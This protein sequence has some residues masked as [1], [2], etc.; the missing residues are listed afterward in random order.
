MSFN[1][2]ED[3]SGVFNDD[4]VN[5]AASYLNESETG[6]SKAL[7]GILP[8]VMKRLLEKSSGTHGINK[9]AQLAQEHYNN[10]I[11]ENPASFFEATGGSMLNKG[12]KLL[13]GLFDDDTDETAATISNFSGIRPASATTLMSIATPVVLGLLGKHAAKNNLNAAGL[14]SSLGVEKKNITAIIP[15]GLDMELINAAIITPDAVVI[16]EEE[17]NNGL[18]WLLPLLL[19]VLSA[20]AI[21]YFWYGTNDKENTNTV[22]VKD[23]SAVI[24]TPVTAY[25]DRAQGTVDADGNFIYYEG[26]TVTITLPGKNG[27]LTFGRYSTEAKLLTFLQDK[28][29]NIDTV[30]GNWFELTNVRFKTG[31]AVIE[32]ASSTQLKNIVTITKAFPAAQFKIG[33]YTDSIGSAAANIALSQKRADAVAAMLIKLGA[34]PASIIGAKGYGPEHPVGDNKTKEGKAMNRRVALNVKRN[35]S[36][37]Y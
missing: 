34:N 3:A 8:V 27:E 31:G 28:S 20:A 30:K 35:A 23:T 29:P 1:L 21:L 5:K 4:F 13:G 6:V 17:N 15:S 10:G 2:L 25:A 19:L 7:S 33:G 16:A 32:D 37:H 14:A 11:A 36:I 18:N 26:D 12:A 24:T 9:I 22:P